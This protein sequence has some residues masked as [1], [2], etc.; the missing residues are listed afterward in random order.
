MMNIIH[1]PEE[2]WGADNHVLEVLQGQASVVVQVGLV[3]DLF[4]HHPHLVFR[5]LV[6]GQLVQR[7]LQVRLAD[8]VI[9]VEVFGKGTKSSKISQLYIQYTQ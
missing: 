3:H 7:L 9:V 8:E 6:T 4:A 1:L 2:L 5:Q